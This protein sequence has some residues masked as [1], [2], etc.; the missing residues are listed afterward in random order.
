VR[1]QSPLLNVEIEFVKLRAK[2]F[3]DAMFL[4]ERIVSETGRAAFGGQ[5]KSWSERQAA[6]RR[7]RQV[8]RA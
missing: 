2:N 4:S 1:V 7:G 5:I 8:R 6:R 3:A